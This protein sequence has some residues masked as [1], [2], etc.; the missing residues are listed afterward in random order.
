MGRRRGSGTVQLP[1]GVHAV[2]A[3]R[4]TYYYWAPRRGASDAPEPISLG[5]DARD[6]EFWTKL[7]AL[8]GATTKEGTFAALI[9]KYKAST[10][11]TKRRHRTQ[12]G[13]EHQI[14]RIEDAWGDMQ[15]SSLTVAG[16]YGLREQF[17]DTPVAANHLMS[18]LSTVLKWGLQHGFGTINPAREIVRL[19]IEDEEA[20]KPWPED[21]WRHIV[22]SAPQDISRAAYLGRACGQRRSD[23]VRYGSR[24]RKDDGIA[25]KIG[26]LRDKEHTIPLTKA[27]LEVIDSWDC[28]DTGPWILSPWRKTMSGDALQAA[29]NRYIAKTPKLQGLTIKWHGLRAMAAIDRK[30]VGAEN[31]AIG[32]S[33][34]MTPAT[35]EKYL[36]NIDMLALARGVRDKLENFT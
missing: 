5:K 29:L 19:E 3:G 32:A 22:D 36:R 12:E 16:I 24:H 33:L 28:S 14:E 27:Q 11:F 25:V 18:V 23:L 35:V 31:K 6:P 13:Y 15:V 30:M 26:K 7:K 9:E 20:A 2:K 10:K 8:S 17:E 21:I 4:V 34:C 1:E